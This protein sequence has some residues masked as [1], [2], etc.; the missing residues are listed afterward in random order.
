MP[1]C[2]YPQMAQIAL[3]GKKILR[4]LLFVSSSYHNACLISS[5]KDFELL[6]THSVSASLSAG[7]SVRR[8]VVRELFLSKKASR[9]FNGVVGFS[10]K[11]SRL[12]NGVAG[13]GKGSLRT[14]SG[15]LVDSLG[16]SSTMSS[17]FLFRVDSPILIL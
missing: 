5:M 12:L 14:K 6:I 13:L 15:A 4:L 3:L 9:L 16:L 17:L 8:E 10:K 7:E 2:N 1:I 11:S